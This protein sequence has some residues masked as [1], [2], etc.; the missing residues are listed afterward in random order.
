MF[1]NIWLVYCKICLHFT[2]RIHLQVEVWFK[3][4]NLEFKFLS[5]LIKIIYLLT[6][7]QISF[8]VFKMLKMIL[9]LTFSQTIK[10]CHTTYRRHFFLKKKDLKHLL[11]VQKK[12]RFLFFS[13]FPFFPFFFYF[14]LPSFNFFHSFFCLSYIICPFRGKR[15]ARASLLRAW[16]FVLLKK[17]QVGIQLEDD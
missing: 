3:K 4:F 14:L 5:I 6:K 17:S 13:F 12:N 16:L 7:D 11:L 2:I 10:N 15:V 1:L 8:S 9:N